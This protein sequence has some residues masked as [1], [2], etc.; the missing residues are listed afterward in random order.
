MYEKQGSFSLLKRICRKQGYSVLYLISISNLEIMNVWLV[1]SSLKRTSISGYCDWWW[2][3]NGWRKQLFISP[4]GGI[5]ED[6]ISGK[7]AYANLSPL[8]CIPTMAGTGSEVKIR[9]SVI[10]LMPTSKNHIKTCL[11]FG[12]PLRF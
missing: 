12:Q 1:Q 8:I 10:T 2:K 4:N 9:S 7:K 6:Y 3:S 11:C 5:P